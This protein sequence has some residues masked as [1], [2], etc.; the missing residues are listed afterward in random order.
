MKKSNKRQAII[1]AAMALFQNHGFEKTSVSQIVKEAGVAQG[2]FYLYFQAKN[3]LIPSIAEFIVEELLA[4]LKKYPQETYEDVQLTLDAL[5]ETTFS[6]TK[7]FKALIAF[8]YSGL[9]FYGSFEKWESM[10]DPYYQYIESKLGYFQ[11]SNKMTCQ[12][13]PNVLANYIVGLLEHGAEMYYLFRNEQDDLAQA[14]KDLKTALY[15]L[16]K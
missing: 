3:D 10:Y 15:Q 8:C 11:S 6:I 16:I 1:E 4:S 2:T 7:E 13:K 5:V 14:K 12:L 9:S